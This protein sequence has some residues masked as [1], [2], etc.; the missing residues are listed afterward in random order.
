MV[1]LLMQLLSVR[2]QDK[3]MV[4]NVSYQELYYYILYFLYSIISLETK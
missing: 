3:A 2:N 4:I 1:A